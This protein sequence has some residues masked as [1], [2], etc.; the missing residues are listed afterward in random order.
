M[1]NVYIFLTFT[2]FRNTWDI[3]RILLVL[4]HTSTFIMFM[5]LLMQNPTDFLFLADKLQEA[6]QRRNLGD[7]FIVLNEH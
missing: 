4:Y 5:L 1:V 6:F 7:F 3:L 2:H